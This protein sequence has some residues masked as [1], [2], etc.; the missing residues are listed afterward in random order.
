MVQIA[1]I[2]AKLPFR[3]KFTTYLRHD[4]IWRHKE[5]ADILLEMGLVAT[6]FGIETLNWE[7][8]KAIGKGLHPDETLEMLHWLRNEKWGNKILTNSNFILGLPKDTYET[9]GNWLEQLMKPDFPLHGWRANPFMLVYIDPKKL[10]NVKRDKQLFLSEIT[11]D[12][13]KFGYE[14]KDVTD[15]SIYGKRNWYNNITGTTFDGVMKLSN[16]SVQPLGSRYWSNW[17]LMSMQN[18]GYDYETL[19]SKPIDLKVFTPEDRVLRRGQLVDRYYKQ[20]MRLP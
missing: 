16:T 12:P 7:S 6:Q 15:K 2:L 1:D 4:L 14:F 19:H 9:M 11:L 13:E 3:V 10:E 5:M 18:L 8:G 17:R 20:L